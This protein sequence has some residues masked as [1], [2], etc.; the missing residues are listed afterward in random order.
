[1]ETMEHL[2]WFLLE[3]SSCLVV[4]LFEYR[5]I[6]QFLSKVMCTSCAVTCVATETQENALKPQGHQLCKQYCHVPH[7]QLLETLGYIQSN[8]YSIKSSAWLSI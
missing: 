3:L 8:T 1:M 5:F 7:A 2:L 4:D 6:I